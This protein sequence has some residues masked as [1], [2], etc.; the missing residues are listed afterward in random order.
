M[1]FLGPFR[2]KI[3]KNQEIAAFEGGAKDSKQV[4]ISVV[5][6]APPFTRQ[7]VD[8]NVE[9]ESAHGEKT[10]VAVDPLSSRAINK[11]NLEDDLHLES[12]LGH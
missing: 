5:N 12:D 6:C 3:L 8:L 7:C 1:N 2:S 9:I 10:E 4:H 11:F